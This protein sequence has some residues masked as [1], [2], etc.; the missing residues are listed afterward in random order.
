VTTEPTGHG[1]SLS[2][3]ERHVAARLRVSEGEASEVLRLVVS[4]LPRA[5]DE[6]L[7]QRMT[8]HLPDPLA[9]VLDAAELVPG[10]TPMGPADAPPEVRPADRARAHRDSVVNTDR[11]RADRKLSSGRGPMDEKTG[12]IADGR[13]ESADPLAEAA[14]GDARSEDEG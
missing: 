8:K 7:R 2:E 4:A 13:A 6:S 11:P 1:A 5:V 10:E 3:A 12:R 14:P 9:R